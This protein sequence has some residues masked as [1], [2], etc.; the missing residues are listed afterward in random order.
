M[1][2]SK[3]ILACVLSGIVGNVFAEPVRIICKFD[4]K[5]IESTEVEFDD[6]IPN[7]LTVGGRSLP[8]SYVGYGDTKNNAEL[9]ELNTATIS[10]SK[11]HQ[12]NGVNFSFFYQINRKTGRI[13]YEFKSDTRHN[14]YRGTCMKM[15]NNGF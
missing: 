1:K 4:E 13:T 11:E 14:V 7:Q 9:I 8:Y 2:I 15:A 5:H 12:A 3:L 10:W 6:N